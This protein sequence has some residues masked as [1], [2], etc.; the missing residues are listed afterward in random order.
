MVRLCVS[1]TVR[2]KEW[3]EG[4]FGEV[5]SWCVVECCVLELCAVSCCRDVCFGV[6]F[7]VAYH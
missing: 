7:Y 6:V 1:V 2:S 3:G 4:R 5:V